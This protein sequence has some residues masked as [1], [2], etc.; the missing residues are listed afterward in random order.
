MEKR[1]AELEKFR[2][3]DP[4]AP[5][6]WFFGRAG[7]SGYTPHFIAMQNMDVKNRRHNEFEPPAPLVQA[8]K[9]FKIA[10]H[11]APAVPANVVAAQNREANP[12]GRAAKRALRTPVVAG[13]R[14]QTG[15]NEEDQHLLIRTECLFPTLYQIR[16]QGLY[17][18]SRCHVACRCAI[19]KFFP[20]RPRRSVPS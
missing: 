9:A 8:R 11:R 17:T 7:R 6:T 2:F 20:A 4:S 3:P 12:P 1:F 16:Q 5:L 18:T 13:A 10:R 15:E 14:R 19:I